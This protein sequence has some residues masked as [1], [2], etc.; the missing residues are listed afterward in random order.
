MGL[1]RVILCIIFP[2]LAVLDKGCGSVL[3]V[4]ILT[5][6]F[7]LPGVLA[8][9]IIS[10]QQQPLVMVMTSEGQLVTP[11]KPHSS[12]ASLFCGVILFIIVASVVT[13]FFKSNSR[14]EI[15]AD[16]ASTDHRGDNEKAAHAAAVKEGIELAKEK[17]LALRKSEGATTPQSPPSVAEAPE[18]KPDL[19]SKDAGSFE[20]SEFPVSVNTTQ[21][22]SLLNKD[23]KDTPIPPGSTIKIVSRA[24]K[25]TLTME[26]N[27]A[28]FVGNESRLAG[29]VKR[30]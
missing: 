21:P 11:A 17:R 15:A 12:L 14:T 6:I 3:L 7:W 13:G 18:K 5:I 9:L 22:L 4:T 25:G 24:E 20:G 30:L 1:I 28:V 16:T 10:S 29:K 2:P 27:G 26:I 19:K 8:A 23:G